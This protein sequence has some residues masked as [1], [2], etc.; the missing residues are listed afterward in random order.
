L[1]STI[2]IFCAIDGPFHRAIPLPGLFGRKLRTSANRFRVE[3]S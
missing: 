1:S 3:T 2:S